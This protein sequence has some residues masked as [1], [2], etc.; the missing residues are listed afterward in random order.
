M[1][2]RSVTPDRLRAA[3]AEALELERALVAAEALVPFDNA[4]AATLA[5]ERLRRLAAWNHARARVVA[6]RRAPTG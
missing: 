4:V 3:E 1:A 5:R 6:L 2:Q